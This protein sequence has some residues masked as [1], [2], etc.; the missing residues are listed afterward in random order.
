MGGINCFK[1]RSIKVAFTVKRLKDEPIVVLKITYPLED[2]VQE[3]IDSDHAV[4]ELGKEIEGRYYRIAD[5][6]GLELSWN[7]VLSWLAQQKKAS[8]GSIN[9]PRIVNLL[10]SDTS[11]TKNSAQFAGQEQYGSVNIKVFDTVEEAIVHA[12]KGKELKF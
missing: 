2:A 3:T 12:R 9:D 8:P 4:A 1:V 5:M 11:M 10:V 7:D 6:L